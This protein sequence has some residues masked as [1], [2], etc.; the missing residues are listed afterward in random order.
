MHGAFEHGAAISKLVVAETF[1]NAAIEMSHRLA[2]FPLSV[3]VVVTTNTV[4]TVISA[5]HRSVNIFSQNVGAHIFKTLWENRGGGWNSKGNDF[6]KC[7]LD[8]Q[9]AQRSIIS[10]AAELVSRC[11]ICGVKIDSR[12]EYAFNCNWAR[13]WNRTPEVL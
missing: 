6:F 5:S 2:V 4:N 12:S 3:P 10:A 13:P 7:E 11:T 8:L 1:S 9:R